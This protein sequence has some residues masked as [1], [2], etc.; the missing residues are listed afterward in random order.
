MDIN[1]QVQIR[2]RAEQRKDL[3]AAFNFGRDVW[4]EVFHE[5]CFRE[6]HYADLFTQMWSAPQRT[7]KKTELYGLLAP[8][9]SRTAARHVQQALEFGLLLEVPSRSDRRQLRVSLSE[10]C[11]LR[12]ERYLD[13]ALVRLTRHLAQR[14]TLPPPL[15]TR[16]LR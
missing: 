16:A 3:A 2:Q 14:H 8:L 9:S 5:P 12:M 4:A 10:E 6:R 15:V 7:F 13:L 1:Q 11:A